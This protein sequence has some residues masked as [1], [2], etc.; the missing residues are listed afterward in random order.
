MLPH[1]YRVSLTTKT[2]YFPFIKRWEY[3]KGMWKYVTFP[4][5]KGATRDIPPH[6][7]FHPSVLERLQASEKYRPKNHVWFYPYNEG[8]PQNRVNYDLHKELHEVDADYIAA[9]ERSSLVK[10]Q[11][12]TQFK[13]YKGV[14]HIEVDQ[15][16]GS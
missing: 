15:I 12:A 4:L 14:Y 6:A 13:L 5:N 1:T 10:K 3:V 8:D 11:P 7:T 9:H 2:E 16:D